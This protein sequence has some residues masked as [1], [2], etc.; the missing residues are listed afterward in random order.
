M[1]RSKKP[2]RKK[3]LVTGGSGYVGSVLLENLYKR[4]FAIRVLDIVP[5]QANTSPI[6]K[7]N[8]EFALGDIRRVSTDIFDDVECIIHLAGISDEVSANNNPELTREVNTIATINLA[9]RAKKAGV[10][11]FIFASS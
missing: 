4:G 11:R 1:K 5:L 10:K 3:V 2:T 7:K 6:L 9:K 8:I